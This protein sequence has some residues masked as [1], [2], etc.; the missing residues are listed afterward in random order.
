MVTVSMP[1]S[2]SSGIFYYISVRTVLQYLNFL[3]WYWSACSYCYRLCC[4]HLA[5][6]NKVGHG[7]SKEGDLPQPKLQNLTACLHHMKRKRPMKWHWSQRRILGADK[8]IERFGINVARKY[9]WERKGVNNGIVV[10]LSLTRRQVRISTGYGT[11]RYL[12]NS[13][14]QQIIDSVIIRKINRTVP[15]GCGMDASRSFLFLEKP[16]NKIQ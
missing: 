13:F 3:S 14:A 12:S 9:A 7:Y 6:Q 8:T 10:V 16:E 2:F 5:I 15:P 4:W 11:E 1:A